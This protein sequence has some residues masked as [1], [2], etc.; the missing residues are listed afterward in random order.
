MT[1]L[2]PELK[3]AMYD[4]EEL[5]AGRPQQ[6]LN[7]FVVSFRVTQTNWITSRRG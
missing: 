3:A 2:L 5:K 7:S 6:S 4:A 1:R